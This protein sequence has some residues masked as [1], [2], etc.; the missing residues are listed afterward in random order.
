MRMLSKV[1]A[2]YT[3]RVLSWIQLKGIGAH[4]MS[5]PGILQTSTL[6]SSPVFS[7]TKRRMHFMYGRCEHSRL[8]WSAQERLHLIT[9]ASM[10]GTVSTSAD[11]V[12]FLHASPTLFR[13]L[14]RSSLHG[15]VQLC[16]K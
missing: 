5:Q 14:A 15:E 13:C 16:Q 10:E 12:T 2:S 3:P 7:T 8:C 1:S 11:L 9:A 6:P 4:H